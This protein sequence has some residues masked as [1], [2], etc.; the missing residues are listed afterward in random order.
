MLDSDS[1]RVGQMCFAIGIPYDLDYSFC[2]GV[3]SAKGR[4]PLES[5]LTNP[6]YEDY[7]QT[8]AF[9]NPGNS[10]GPLFDIDGKVMGM[11][12]LINGLAR[13]LSFAIP[14]NMLDQVGS[15]LIAT[16]HVIHPWLGISVQSL[17]DEPSAPQRFP[18][19]TEGVCVDTIEANAPAYK[20]D[21]RPMDVIT[22][23][24]GVS[25]ITSHDLQREILRKNVGQTVSLTVWRAGKTFDIPVVT[26]ALP[27]DLTTIAR[28]APRAKIRPADDTSYGLQ[29]STQPQPVHDANGAAVTE[30]QPDSPAGRAGLQPGD[31]ITAVDQK[32][33]TDAPS[34]LELLAAHRG[35][36]GPLVF[37]TRSGQKIR[38]VLDSGSPTP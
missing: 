16:G 28:N 37:F 31:V 6:M 14:S 22:K 9:I 19:L 29:F 4:G 34:A 15:A 24:D 11:N 12:T 33:V 2:R 3:V 20:S 26:D 1:V 21:L 18:G 32:P 17:D 23:V 30:V 38:A 35:A 8:D 25:V 36:K 27:T 5:T 13:G 7:I 10:G